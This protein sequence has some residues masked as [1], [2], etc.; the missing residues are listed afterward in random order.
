MWVLVTGGAG[1]IG[2]T[3]VRQLLG[4]EHF[5]RVLDNLTYATG[6][7]WD[8]LN[9]LD[10]HNI[11]KGDIRDYDRC[12][13]ALQ[14]IDAVIHFAAESH[15]TRSEEAEDLFRDVN[16]YG[17]ENILAAACDAGVRHFIHISTDEVYGPAPPGIFFRE[18]DKKV[19]DKQATSPYAK[20]KALADDSVCGWMDIDV[21]SS[22]AIVRPTNNFGPRQHLEKA[23]PRWITHI[24]R[25]Q[26]IPI[27]GEGNQVRDWLFVED[28]CQAI[29]MLFE[30]NIS[31]VYNIAA[32]N[33]PEI[34][35]LEMA[36]RVIS[37]LHDGQDPEK[38]I[39]F[40][41]DPRPDHDFRYGISTEKIHNKTG[42]QPSTSLDD[43]L[44]QTVEWY[45]NHEKWWRRRIEDAENLYAG[46]EQT[47]R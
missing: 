3:M 21:F 16:C 12:L 34:T 15:V 42:W 30:G 11:L 14:E 23:L 19:E 40:I 4:H 13:S 5:V 2:S 27:W 37:I 41:E 46:K 10:V 43:A 17:T 1:F 20:S 35:N 45:F 9:G 24:L 7:S 25:G 47:R 31:G 44:R 36:K 28:C 29:M 18:E 6:N 32:N 39:E 26:K 8:N 22:L 38:Y 33:L